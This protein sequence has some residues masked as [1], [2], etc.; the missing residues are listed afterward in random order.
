MT[1]EGFGEQ[2][3]T[4]FCGLERDN[5][6]D[7]WHSHKDVYDEHV[8]GPMAALAEELEPRFG[9]AKLFRPQRDTRFSSDKAPYKTYQGVSFSNVNADSVGYFAQIDA[10]GVVALAGLH[11]FGSG[12]LE[13]YRAAV[14]D[15][16]SGPAFDKA[17]KELRRRGFE[18]EGEQL[19]TRPRGT[20]EDHPRLELLRYRS[21]G[22]ARR[23]EPSKALHTRRALN[24]V[25]RDFEKLRPVVT[26]LERHCST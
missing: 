5:S 6:K 24:M 7:Y 13:R 23:H 19:K 11:P 25:T 4:F 10:E 22:L 8:R 15:E 18:I 9:K 1:F 21:L 3:F 17:V 12:V 14:S 20:P 2:A 26:W 16:R